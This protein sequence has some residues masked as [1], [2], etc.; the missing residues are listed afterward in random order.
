MAEKDMSNRGFGGMEE[1]RQKEI[2]SKSGH[3]SHE[4]GRRSRVHF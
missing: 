1:D 3:A 2:A 4:K